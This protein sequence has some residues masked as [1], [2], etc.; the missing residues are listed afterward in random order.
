MV[1]TT[2]G[3]GLAYRDGGRGI[4]RPII[5]WLNDSPVPGVTQGLKEGLLGMR[6][7]GKRTFTVPAGQG[8]GAS[9]VLGPYAVIPGGSALTYSVEVLRLSRVPSDL[10]KGVVRC[11]QGGMSASI[12]GCANI[13]PLE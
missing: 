12:D 10:M 6:V 7:G 4:L 13:V 1:D 3:E 2:R 11:S 5:V 8:F 9:T